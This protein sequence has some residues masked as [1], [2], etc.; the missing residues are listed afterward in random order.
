MARDKMRPRAGAAGAAEAAGSGAAAPQRGEELDASGLASL[1][2]DR[3]CEHLVQL[4][5]DAK[6]CAM[7]GDVG[8]IH[9]HLENITAAAAT[10]SGEQLRLLE[11]TEA[12]L[13]GMARTDLGRREVALHVFFTRHTR[14]ADAL[15]ARLL[16]PSPLRPAD[17]EGLAEDVQKDMAE[18]LKVGV[19]R[20]EG[21]DIG[22]SPA[23]VANALELREPAAFRMWLQVERCR[24]EIG[25]AESAPEER[26]RYLASQLGITEEQARRHLE[27]YP[28]PAHAP[29][30]A[31][32]RPVDPPSGERYRRDALDEVFEDAEPSS[33]ARE[34]G[35]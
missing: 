22:L 6:R 1:D 15:F 27:R 9:R 20:Q 26:A 32:A 17:M 11:V 18:L 14:E 33:K 35:S 13:S 2:P 7:E 23:M 10:A 5:G 24:K 4:A 3:L 28:P 25:S 16:E 31:K 21:E 8:W 12:F 19:L 34:S 30:L 29:R